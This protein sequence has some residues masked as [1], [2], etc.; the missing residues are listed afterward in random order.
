MNDL[1][2]LIEIGDGKKWFI[3]ARTQYKNEWYGYL[4]R[5]N[6]A[7]DDLLDEYRIIK[8]IIKEDGEYVSIIKNRETLKEVIPLLLPEVQEYLDAKR[9]G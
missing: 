5:L 6:D 2:N 9:Q 1:Y 8:T 3:A 7:E 4:I